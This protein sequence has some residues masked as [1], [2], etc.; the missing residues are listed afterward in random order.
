MTAARRA[1]HDDALRS[2]VETEP[3][4][5]SGNSNQSPD[6]TAGVCRLAARWASQI[7]GRSRRPD[8]RAVG[9]ATFGRAC[10]RVRAD[11]QNTT[12]RPRAFVNTNCDRDS[13]DLDRAPDQSQHSAAHTTRPEP[14]RRSQDLRCR[15]APWPDGKTPLQYEA[16]CPSPSTR[17][18]SVPPANAP[19]TAM[20]TLC[21]DSGR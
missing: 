2:N 16:T 4:L 3:G 18:V 21:Q 8:A 12:S 15:A 11:C 19:E 13:P 20:S 6:F 14:A 1:L 17:P 10:L 5:L 7:S 9:T